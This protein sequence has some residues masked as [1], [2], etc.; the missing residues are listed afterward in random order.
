MQKTDSNDKKIDNLRKT[1]ETKRAALGSKPRMQYLTNG[2]MPTGQKNVNLNILRTVSDC[3][4]ACS[5]IALKIVAHEKAS[6]ILGVDTGVCTIGDYP[7][8]D[9]ISDIKLKLSS[10]QWQEEK[11]KLDKMDLTLSNLLSE[12]AKTTNMIDDIENSLK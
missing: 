8:S 6:E 9:W 2:V 3:F 5:D 12:Q 7:A 11:L 10:I 1:I 4:L